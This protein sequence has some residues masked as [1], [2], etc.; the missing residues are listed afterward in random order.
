MISGGS[1]GRVDVV[2]G[3]TVVVVAG[4]AFPQAAPTVPSARA[5]ATAGSDARRARPRCAGRV[6][7]TP[8]FPVGPASVDEPPARGTQSCGAY[9]HASISTAAPIGRSDTAIA[10]RAGR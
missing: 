7:G 4:L 10:E 1:G 6:N 3:G 9:A 8:G 2:C 5:R